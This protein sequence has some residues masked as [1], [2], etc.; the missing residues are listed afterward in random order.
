MI[1]TLYDST[2][3]IIK[4]YLEA[5]YEYYLDIDNCYDLTFDDKASF[6]A[7]MKSVNAEYVGVDED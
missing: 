6:E 1:Y 2:E 5:G 7:Y 3:G 4:V